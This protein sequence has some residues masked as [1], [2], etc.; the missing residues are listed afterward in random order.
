MQSQQWEGSHSF[1]VLNI[2]H[3]DTEIYGA[4]VIYC[5]VCLGV[6]CVVAE[7]RSGPRWPGGFPED[8]EVVDTWGVPGLLWQTGRW[9]R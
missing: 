9:N 2:T 7:A 6:G 1:C 3:D 4:A 8:H 5:G